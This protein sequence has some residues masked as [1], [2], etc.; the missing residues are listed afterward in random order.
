M[1]FD[2]KVDPDKCSAKYS[3]KEKVL[4]VVICRVK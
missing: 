3:K 4:T 2:F 1:K